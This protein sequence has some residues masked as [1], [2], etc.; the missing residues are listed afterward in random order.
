[1]QCIDKSH[2]ATAKVMGGG[3]GLGLNIYTFKPD[4]QKAPSRIK[5]DLK[6]Q[7][8]VLHDFSNFTTYICINIIGFCKRK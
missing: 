6:I 4:M 8:F 1:M 5:I 3:G 2:L 7:N